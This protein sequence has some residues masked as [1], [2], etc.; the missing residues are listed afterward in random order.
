[1]ICPIESSRS[2]SYISFNQK[3]RNRALVLLKEIL[4][5]TNC[6]TKEEKQNY[7]SFPRV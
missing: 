5:I 2:Y 6:K 7:E 4:M 3:I 1:M